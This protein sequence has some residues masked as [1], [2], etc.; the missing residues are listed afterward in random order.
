MLGGDFGHAGRAR[1]S[2]DSI[3]KGEG[4]F[5]EAMELE[6]LVANVWRLEGGLTVVRC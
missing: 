3:V 5:M 6:S 2:A 4:A 1:R